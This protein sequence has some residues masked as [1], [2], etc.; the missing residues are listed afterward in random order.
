M[1]N[2]KLSQPE[3]NQLQISEPNRALY[4]FFFFFI[5]IFV[6]ASEEVGIVSLLP[7]LYDG[8]FGKEKKKYTAV[9]KCSRKKMLFLFWAKLGRKLL[10]P[11]RM[12]FNLFSHGLQKKLHY[13][14]TSLSSRYTSSSYLSLSLVWG[15]CMVGMPLVGKKE[16]YW[17]AEWMEKQENTNLST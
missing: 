1:L 3:A 12:V 13:S 10:N 17:Q 4:R 2:I 7:I 6:A 15:Y 5:E 8:L 14:M 9:I 16:N 11:N